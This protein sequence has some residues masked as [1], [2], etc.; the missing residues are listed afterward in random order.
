MCIMMG[1]EESYQQSCEDMTDKQ[2]TQDNVYEEEHKISKTG[3]SKVTLIACK[4]SQ[5]S[6][7]CLQGTVMRKPN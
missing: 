2:R 6:K 4:Q 7:E 1:K 5:G 3:L